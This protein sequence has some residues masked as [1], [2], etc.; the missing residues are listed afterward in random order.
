MNL[1][2]C[3]GNDAREDIC[4]T[5]PEVGGVLGALGG[6]ALES[7]RLVHVS[8]AD[9]KTIMM[10]KSILGLCEELEEILSGPGCAPVIPEVELAECFVTE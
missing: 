3:S 5:T 2:N 1:K 7:A 6:S 9:R 4:Q 8:S 10:G